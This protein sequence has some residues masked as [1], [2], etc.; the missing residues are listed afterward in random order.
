M[1]FLSY[2]FNVLKTETVW[3][4]SLYIVQL[5]TCIVLAQSDNIIK[6]HAKE[7]GTRTIYSTFDVFSL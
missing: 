7:E 6:S 5:H 3:S 4:R 2:L 1:M